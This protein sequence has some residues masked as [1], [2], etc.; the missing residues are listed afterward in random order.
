M[1]SLAYAFERVYSAVLWSKFYSL[2]ENKLDFDES[3]LERQCLDRI[4]ELN[5][6]K[7]LL[8]FY[9]PQSTI[10][11]IDL[12]TP[13]SYFEQG[14]YDLC[15]FEALKT[16]ATI[17]V[18]NTYLFVNNERFNETI[19]KKLDAALTE[20]RKQTAKGYFPIVAYSYYTYAKQLAEQGDVSLAILFSEYAIEL[21]KMDLFINQQKTFHLNVYILALLL[22]VSLGVF[23]RDVVYVLK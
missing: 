10:A 16:R 21:S 1:F 4:H 15:L 17:N 12:E 9:L 18:Y 3:Y 22:G 20:I 2:D 7:E 13:Q 19:S 11:S 6:M 23:V 5:S 8:K 14:K